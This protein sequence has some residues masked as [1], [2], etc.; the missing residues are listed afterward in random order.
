MG[1][2]YGLLLITNYQLVTFDITNAGYLEIE[3]LT[4]NLLIKFLYILSN[5]N[6]II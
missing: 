6:S 1:L 2:Y 5:G 4:W 3:I